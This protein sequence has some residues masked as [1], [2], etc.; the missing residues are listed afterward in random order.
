MKVV[1]YIR[2]SGLGQVDKDGP[3]RQHEAIVQFCALN[4]LEPVQEYEELGVSGTVD[5]L[6]RPK[7][8]EMISDIDANPGV[9]QAIVVERM[10]RLARHLMVSEVLLRE[11]RDRNIKVF[12]TD[13][14][15]LV[16]MAAD[17]DDPTKT[18][19]R[20]LFGILAQW[21]KSVTV[22]KL[23]Y[24]RE[25]IR[26]TKGRCEGPLPY[27][28]DAKEKHVLEKIAGF[29]EKKMSYAEIA[30]RLNS[31]GYLPRNAVQWTKTTVIGALGLKRKKA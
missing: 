17:G 23:R 13:Q 30:E 6:E 14:P 15:G 26:L 29:R 24:A 28:K 31:M 27:G 16:D 8:A 19:I 22:K 4:K 20:Q 2:V 5:G 3:L 9:I 10:D 18:L 7:F 21:E 11:L 25:R 1:S 12:S